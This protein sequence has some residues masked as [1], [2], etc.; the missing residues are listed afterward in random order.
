[1]VAVKVWLA[2]EGP[3]EIGNRE[4]GG[5]RVGVL[6]ALLRRIEPTG[7]VVD[8]ASI[9]KDIRKYKAG[10]ALRGAGDDRSIQRLVLFA[11][12]AGCEVVAF[13]RDRDS[14]PERETT[15]KDGL[16]AVTAAYPSVGVI[17]GLAKPCI[18]GWVLALA[19]VKQT[20]AMSRPR[21][22]S[23]LAN[24]DLL[25]AEPA[26]EAFVAIVDRANLD[27]LPNGCD[28][29]TTW[30][31]RARAVLSPAVHGVPAHPR[32]DPR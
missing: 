2:G 8:R 21:C 28:S 4:T 25:A 30:L 13:S 27:A 15:I 16:A 6:E 3:S 18:E 11:Y 1:M 29:L 20:E 14:D 32:P 7:W 19:G 23:E 22:D 26:V 12:E 17:G 5:E 9:W 24:R 31:A 10:S